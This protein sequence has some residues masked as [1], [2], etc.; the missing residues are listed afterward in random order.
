MSMI[1]ILDDTRSIADLASMMPKVYQN[2]DIT[3]IIICR[4]VKDGVKFVKAYG[5]PERI[6]LDHDLGGKKSGLDFCKFLVE[7][8]IKGNIDLSTTRIYYHSTNHVGVDNMIGYIDS[9]LC[10]THRKKRITHV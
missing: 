9:Y 1:L 8:D 3:A 5:I 2:I 10:S 4:T 7:E 6:S